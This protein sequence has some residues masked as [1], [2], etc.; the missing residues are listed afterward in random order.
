MNVLFISIILWTVVSSYYS[1]VRNY[2]KYNTKH[3]Y[4]YYS[5][6]YTY[7]SEPSPP[8]DNNDFPLY[9]VIWDKSE[10]TDKL[11]HEMEIQGLYT[12]FIEDKWDIMDNQ[13]NI[14]T[15]EIPLVYKDDVLLESWME[16]YAEMYP[17]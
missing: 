15:K 16:I 10:K 9:I 5:D 14:S 11:L 6:Y 13:I 8:S 7:Y 1:F 3:Y 4:T 17:M 12:Y 2:N